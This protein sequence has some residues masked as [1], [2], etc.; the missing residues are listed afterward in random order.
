[1]SSVAVVGGGVVGM[2]CALRL[3]HAGHGV[4]LID[5][6]DRRSPASWGNAGHIAIEQVAPLASLAT[7]RSLPGRL[8]SRGGPVALPL[9]MIGRWG[10]F[11]LR[12][13]SASTPARFARS[14]QALSALLA[15]AAPAWQRLTADLGDPGLVRMDGHFV[16]WERAGTAA[17]GRAAIASEGMGTASVRDLTAAERA[18]LRGLTSTIEDGLRFSGTGQ[19]ADLD[20]LANAFDA[21][22][23]SAGVSRERRLGRIEVASGDRVS[24]PGV[25][26]EFVLI[27]A[28]VASADLMR[29][30]GHRAPLIAERGYHIRSRNFDLPDNVPPLVFEDRSIIVT[31]F[32]HC[33]QAAGFVEFGTPDASPDPRKWQRLEGHIAELGLPIRPPFARWMGSRPTLPDYLPAIGRSA[34]H[35]NLLYAFGHQHLGLTLAAITGELVT[36]M[37][38]G[39]PPAIDLSPF[40]L[41]RFG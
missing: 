8:F 14:K 23:R 1:M 30:A 18:D 34:R 41:A 38:S 21:A 6:G 12:F 3:A 17:A 4:A 31:R 36:Q 25:D 26:A 28:G 16:L 22:L 5:P 7:L 32:R 39:D 40:G 37:V 29:A 10:P 33:V 20:D 35:P 2:S 15:E 9:A 24:V 27:A 19:V 13:L 11:A